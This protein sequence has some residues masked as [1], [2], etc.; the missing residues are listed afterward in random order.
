MSSGGVHAI[1][2]LS[3]AC[4]FRSRYSGTLGHLLVQALCSTQSQRRKDQQQDNSRHD[5]INPKPYW[6]PF[7]LGN[8]QISFEPEICSASFGLFGMPE[9][10]DSTIEGPRLGSRVYIKFCLFLQRPFTSAR[11]NDILLSSQKST[12]YSGKAHTKPAS[13]A[14]IYMLMLRV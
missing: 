9:G 14:A 6:G 7:I 1:Q 5:R 2:L 12:S 13:H 8:Y 3:A 4:S 11:H 10:R